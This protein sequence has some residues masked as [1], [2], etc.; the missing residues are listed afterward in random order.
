MFYFS[1]AERNSQ[2][3]VV[4]RINSLILNNDKQ[5]NNWI[6][7]WVSSEE[8]KTLDNSLDPTVTNIANG[9][10]SLNFNNSVVAQKSSSSLYRNF[11]LKL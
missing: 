7:T 3:I 8:M 6:S 1:T 9:R 10:V 5:V 2:A 4:I 11:I